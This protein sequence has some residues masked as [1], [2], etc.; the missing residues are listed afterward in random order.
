[1]CLCRAGPW[2][3]PLSSSPSFLRVG[4][5]LQ[6]RSSYGSRNGITMWNLIT[7]DVAEQKPRFLNTIEQLTKAN[8]IRN[9]IS[10]AS[11]WRRV[12]K[13]LYTDL[14]DRIALWE[15]TGVCSSPTR[16]VTSEWVPFS[17]SNLNWLENWFDV[18][19][20]SALASSTGWSLC[21]T[22]IS[23]ENSSQI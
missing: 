8:W 2:R 18:T 13:V 5:L 3:F 9:R 16:K 20:G 6:N 22:Q 14:A 21:S 15:G 4:T 11:F 19:I 23:S 10:S 17:R 12:D 1:M 7:R